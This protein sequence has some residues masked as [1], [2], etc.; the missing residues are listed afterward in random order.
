MHSESDTDSC[1][2]YP[3]R[4]IHVGREEEDALKLCE[5]DQPGNWMSKPGRDCKL[6]YLSLIYC[7]GTEAFLTTT[8]SNIDK[9]K[10]LI[11]EQELPQA[12]LDAI[13]VTRALGFQ[14]LWCD[15]LCIIQGTDQVAVED[16]ENESKLMADIYSNSFLTICA[17]SSHNATSTFLHPREAPGEQVRMTLHS[18]FQWSVYKQGSHEIVLSE[19]FYNVSEEQEPL[20]KRGWTLQER[21]LSNRLLIFG[22]DEL[23]WVCRSACVR[24]NGVPTNASLPT[25]DSAWHSIVED[26]S[27]RSLTR[28]SDRLVAILG[29]ATLFATQV[30]H[31]YYGCDYYMGLWASTFAND[32]LWFHR[33]RAASS[34]DER[35][36][37]ILSE[38]PSWSWASTS[39]D[40]RFIK[41]SAEPSPPTSFKL[42]HCSKI[43][44][45]WPLRSEACH[46]TA[47]IISGRT[48]HVEAIKCRQQ[49]RYDEIAND[50]CSLSFLGCALT[51]FVD[52]PFEI[53]GVVD[54]EYKGATERYVR[55]VWFLQVSAR[56]GLIL[57]KLPNA[58]VPIPNSI[59]AKLYEKVLAS[60]TFQMIGV[61][62]VE[63]TSD[64]PLNFQKRSLIRL[65]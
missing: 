37:K 19:P 53:T 38:V 20:D 12:I 42:R 48:A 29:V 43:G 22:T 18:S 39:G 45:Q 36:R 56:A 2:F 16:W 57:R 58:R 47:A 4:L 34:P 14:Y 63:H 24:E 54:R 60:R 30:G 9:L 44:S 23:T 8:T 61:Y 6:D 50:A 7:W 17:A 28:S 25:R 65:V 15:A 46:Y 11:P 1:S 5:F 13:R 52:Y 59:P 26:Y 3:R 35:P 27:S 33:L 55:D 32:L 40:V 31:Q 41:A 49:G 62:K 64:V 51:T 21:L 10:L